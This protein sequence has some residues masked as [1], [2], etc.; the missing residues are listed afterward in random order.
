MNTQ[1]AIFQLTGEDLD[2]VLG[3]GWEDFVEGVSE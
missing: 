2:D 1:E 3:T